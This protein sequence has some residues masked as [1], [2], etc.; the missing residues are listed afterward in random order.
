[1]TPP[2]H[3]YYMHMYSSATFHKFTLNNTLEVTK[4][5][6][7]QAV[8]DTLSIDQKFKVNYNLSTLVPDLCTVKTNISHH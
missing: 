1:M 4:I 7:L 8:H 3:C 6:M 2:I 5:Q